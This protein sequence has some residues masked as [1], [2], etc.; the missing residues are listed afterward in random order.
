MQ[1]YCPRL[2]TEVQPS[3]RLALSVVRC[4]AG[5]MR[6]GPCAPLPCQRPECSHCPQLPGPHMLSLPPSPQ[7]W[8]ATMFPRL[9]GCAPSRRHAVGVLQRVA[10][11]DGPP[12]FCRV[13]SWPDGLFLLSAGQNSS[14]ARSLSKGH[15]GASRAG[16]FGRKML[17][18][19]VCGF[20]CDA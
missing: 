18:T 9:C 11:P 15:L 1:R 12:W 10:F 13:F 16:Q 17:Y 2:L 6:D 14:P 4:V 3:V 20:L 7:A 19:L 5:Q 8:A